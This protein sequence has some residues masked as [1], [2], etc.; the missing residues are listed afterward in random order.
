MNEYCNCMAV[1]YVVPAGYLLILGWEECEW[2]GRG[3]FKLQS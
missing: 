1:G 3:L 2:Y